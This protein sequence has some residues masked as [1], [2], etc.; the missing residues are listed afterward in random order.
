MSSAPTR[1]TNYACDMHCH[2]NRSDG[3]DSPRELIDR[4]A[5]L[6]MHAIAITDHDITPPT[7]IVDANGVCICLNQYARNAGVIVVPGYEFSTDSLVDE[8]H[9]CGYNL[10]WNAP[11]LL[12]EVKSAANSKTNAYFE[13][14]ERLSTAGYRINWEEDIL[15]YQTRQGEL[16]RREPEAVQRKHIFEAMAIKGYAPNWQTAKLMVRDNVNLNVRRRK[17]DPY[18][19]IRLIHSCGGFAILAHPYLIDD[20]ITTRGEKPT[21]RFEYIEDLIDSGLDG[22]E[23][24]YT[25]DKTTYKGTLTPRQIE[26]ETRKLYGN[27]VAI[28]SGGSD[29][30]ADQKKGERKYREL[31]ECGISI[32]EFDQYFVKNMHK[33]VASL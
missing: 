25:Y 10:D 28:L 33:T 12:A 9:I 23:V 1:F 5:A 19:A 2:T 20:P 4:A 11:D 3:L 27:R 24:R 8:V 31:G 18:Q 29:Y 21:G 32:E 17:I 22:I 16:M 7:E 26:M 14:C 13:L 6:G 30:H 15:T